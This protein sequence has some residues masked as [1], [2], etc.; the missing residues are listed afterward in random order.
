ML[1]GI[2]CA[3]RAGPVVAVV[4]GGSGSSDR[5]DDPFET[6]RTRLFPISAIYKLPAESSARP[7]MAANCARRAGPLSPAKP[8]EPLPATVLMT[9]FETLRTR[10]LPPSAMYRLPH[11][12]IAT[13]CGRFNWAW[14]AGPPSPPKPCVPSPAIVTIC[15]L[16]TLRTRLQLK[17]AI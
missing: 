11:G 3:W 9:P 7:E 15:P 2:N 13:P 5:R 12:S 16:E 17:S 4:T 8:A 14:F 6:I 10:W 1:Y